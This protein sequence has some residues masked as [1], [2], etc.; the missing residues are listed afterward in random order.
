MK[1][2]QL[3]IAAIILG[4]TDEM[5]TDQHTVV[6]TLG[7]CIDHSSHYD[8]IDASGKGVSPTAC[9]PAGEGASAEAEALRVLASFVGKIG[10]W[11][12]YHRSAALHLNRWIYFS[13]KKE[14]VAS[15]Y[16]NIKIQN[17]LNITFDFAILL[18]GYW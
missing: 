3:R 15:K 7:L 8:D 9:S 1:I 6:S 10:K 4:N 18:Q 5:P 13:D 14:N 11:N 12:K 2:L 16:K 17:W